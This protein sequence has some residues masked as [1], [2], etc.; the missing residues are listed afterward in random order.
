[1]VK[2]TDRLFEE[3]T[4]DLVRYQNWLVHLEKVDDGT[5]CD[6]KEVVATIAFCIERLNT[7]LVARE[8]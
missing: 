1:M 2:A 7:I 8:K 6:I 3:V 4:R 5:E